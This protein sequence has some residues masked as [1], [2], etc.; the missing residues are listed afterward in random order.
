MTSDIDLLK[1]MTRQYYVRDIGGEG[2][3]EYRT[4]NFV[5]KSWRKFY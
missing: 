3:R 4:E 5:P 1:E 2:A